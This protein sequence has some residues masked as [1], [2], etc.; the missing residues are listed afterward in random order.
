MN[1][2][3][4]GYQNINFCDKVQLEHV[5][6]SKVLHNNEAI[7]FLMACTVVQSK[8]I[9]FYKLFM[10]V[11]VPFNTL[12]NSKLVNYSNHNQSLKFHK[13][14]IYEPFFFEIDFKIL[15]KLYRLKCFEKSTNLATKY[16]KRS[17]LNG[18][19]TFAKNLEEINSLH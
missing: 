9:F 1:K 12:Q 15:T 5:N 19:M 7:T 17:V 6:E 2:I 11:V 3:V 4:L 8:S 13:N 18:T 14:P 16:V 10:D